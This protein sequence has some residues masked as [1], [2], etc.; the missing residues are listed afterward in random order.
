V[1][2][3][4]VLALLGLFGIF[5]AGV[6][7]DAILSPR[8]TPDE[9][10]E[11]EPV[12]DDEQDFSAG[13]LLDPDPLDGLPHSDDLADPPPENLSVKGT[14]SS[15]VLSGKDGDDDISG[16]GGD[17]LIDGRAG[18]DRINAGA[19][20]DVVWAG[21]GNDALFGGAGDDS[22]QGQD[23][24]DLL[25]GGFGDDTLSG[26]SGDDALAGGAGDDTLLG[27]AGDDSLD[28]G[29]G[30]DWLAGGEGGDRL[31]GDAGSDTLDGNAGDD[32]LSGL[33]GQVDDNAQDFLNGGVGN[34][35]M[36]LGSGDHAHGD[37]GEDDFVI[38]DWLTEGGVAHVSDYDSSMDKL[39]VVYDPA[40]HPDPILSVEVAPDGSESTLLLDGAP[41]ATVR[42]DI[43][44]LADIELRAA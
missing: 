33:D 1:K 3:S 7:A 38:Q 14:E 18:D 34:D 35:T 28:G 42:G 13:N 11:P 31:A 26:Q 44:D 29:E 4:G 21:S 17:D 41:V 27:G 2:G 37:A 32:W 25:D 16:A 20:D 9:D 19:G 43:V 22:L 24:E 15:E 36:I 30:D 40:V 12:S 39:V 23:G 8:D 6:A 10:D 5:A